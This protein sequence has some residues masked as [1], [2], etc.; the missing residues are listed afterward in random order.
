LLLV[1]RPARRTLAEVPLADL[2]FHVQQGHLDVPYLRHWSAEMLEPAA[3]RELD[4]LIATYE[5][6]DP[7]EPP[8]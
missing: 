6:A 8:D 4:E 3:V 5:V 1:I 7:P 2:S